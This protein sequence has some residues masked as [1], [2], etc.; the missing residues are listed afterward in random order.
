MSYR[1]LVWRCSGGTD[2]KHFAHVF[3]VPLLG[4]VTQL[5]CDVDPSTNV[6]INLHGFFLDFGVQFWHLLF[7][8]KKKNSL[9]ST[10]CRGYPVSSVEKDEQSLRND[11]WE[12]QRTSWPCHFLLNNKISIHSYSRDPF[13]R[14]GLSIFL[15]YTAFERRFYI[16]R[17]TCSPRSA[18]ILV[19]ETNPQCSDLFE[20]MI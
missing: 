5:G 8:A 1:F 17:K 18:L 20:N 11:L 2:V 7:G 12:H 13:P 19:Q 9:P 10:W 14:Q 3:R 6:H 16:E 15:D 4:H